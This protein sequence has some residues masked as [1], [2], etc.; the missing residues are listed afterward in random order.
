MAARDDDAQKEFPLNRRGSP[1]SGLLHSFPSWQGVDSVV[2]AHR[3]EVNRRRATAVNS[4][5]TVVSHVYPAVHR[6]AGIVS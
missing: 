6:D 5:S 2:R 3:I 1:G 4:L